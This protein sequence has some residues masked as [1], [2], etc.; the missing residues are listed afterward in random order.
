MHKQKLPTGTC[1]T[2]GAA[3]EF[4]KYLTGAVTLKQYRKMQGKLTEVIFTVD[5]KVDDS[6]MYVVDWRAITLYAVFVYVPIF[7]IDLYHK[8]LSSL[9]KF[10]VIWN[11]VLGLTLTL[12][13]C[14]LSTGGGL[15]RKLKKV[16]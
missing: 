12:M 5:N 16:R 1:V 14:L 6:E 11:L 13:T 7:S 3:V 4:R 2:F 8:P 9:T 15:P 10:D